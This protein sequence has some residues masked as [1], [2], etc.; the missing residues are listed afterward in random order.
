MASGNVPSWAA[1]VVMV[2]FFIKNGG[3]RGE[4]EMTF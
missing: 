1:A 3:V 2:F 4:I